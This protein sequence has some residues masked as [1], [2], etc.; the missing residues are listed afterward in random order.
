MFIVR[1]IK[2]TSGEF[3]ERQKHYFELADKGEKIVITRG[4]RQAYML[5]PISEDDLYFTPEMIQDI[6][7]AQQEI[8]EGKVTSLKS[9]D[10]MNKFFDS[11]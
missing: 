10:E 2:I 4:I 5:E 6:K 3:R 9:I 7:D 8:K 11:L 1:F